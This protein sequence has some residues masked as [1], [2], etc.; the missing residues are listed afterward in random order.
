MS[1]PGPRLR[2]LQSQVAFSWFAWAFQVME[3]SHIC[4]SEEF[5][6]IC[7]GCCMFH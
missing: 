4:F 5:S 7:V 6:Q 1:W 2:R 3:V